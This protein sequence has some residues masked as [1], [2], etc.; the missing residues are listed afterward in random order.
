MSQESQ[1]RADSIRLYLLSQAN[2]ELPRFAGE[3]GVLQDQRCGMLE[4][5]FDLDRLVGA[6][7]AALNAQWRNSEGRS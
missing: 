3:V 2:V 5:P 7:K 6:I 4:K 1:Q